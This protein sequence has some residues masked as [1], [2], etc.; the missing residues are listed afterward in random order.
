LRVYESVE[1]EMR[2]VESHPAPDASLL[3]LAV[4]PGVRERT[5]WALAAPGPERSQAALIRYSLKRRLPFADF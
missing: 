5:V 1:G 2:R 4:L 3:G